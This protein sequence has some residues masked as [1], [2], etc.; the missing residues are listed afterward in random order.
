[1]NKNVVFP[2]LGILVQKLFI[3]VQVTNST[4]TG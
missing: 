4:E 3:R 2:I 1:M